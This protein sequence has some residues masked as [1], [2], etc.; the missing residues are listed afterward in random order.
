[1]RPKPLRVICLCGMQPIIE[2]QTKP[3]SEWVFGRV[4]QKVSP[5][6][7]HANAQT[8]VAAALMAWADTNG[9]GRVGTEWEFRIAP[10]SEEFR[11]LV[12]D[13]AFL[14]YD[15]LGFD[16]EK[17][18]QMPAVAPNIAVEILSPNDRKRDVEEKIRV[19]LASGTDL[20]VV[21]DPERKEVAMHDSRSVSMLHC[22][23]ML[24]H[25]ALPEFSMAVS[26]IFARPG[27][28]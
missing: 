11:S 20:V 15:R 19:Y 26:D 10:P 18:A 14:S 5:T 7:K 22:G 27:E 9:V 24:R 12:P 25:R 1:M 8:R 17:A 23:D 13:V 16:E 4:V 3:A 2:Q 21:A 28:R 6:A